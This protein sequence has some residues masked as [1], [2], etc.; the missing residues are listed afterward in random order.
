MAT[1]VGTIQVI[2]ILDTSQ[3]KAGVAQVNAANKNMSSST[4]SA[5]SRMRS[6]LNKVG[7]AAVA[8]A[9]VAAGA[10]IIK[11]LGNA[12]SRVDTLNNFPKVMANLGYGAA[13]AT[14]AINTLDKG[15]QGLPT[16]LDS[17]ASALQ[18]IA[19]SAKSLDYATKLTLALNNALIAGGKPAELQATAMEQFSQAIAKGK[20][21]LIEWRSVATAMP[22]QMKQLANSLGYDKWQQ[23]A[24]AV[25]DGKLSFEDV[26]DAIIKLNEKG[27]GKFPSFAEQ[28]KNAAGGLRTSI[29]QMNTAITRGIGEVIKSIGSDN[30]SSGFE[31]IGKGFENGL[32]GIATGI[33]IV[34]QFL[35]PIID[36]LTEM[37]N[38]IKSDKQFMD[39]L[40]LAFQT[41]GMYLGWLGQQFQLFIEWA[42]QNEQVMEGLKIVAIGLAIAIGAAV[43]AFAAA[44]GVI[45]GAVVLVTAAIGNARQFIVDSFNNISNAA[46]SLGTWLYNTWNSIKNTI[47]TVMVNIGNF[48]INTWNNIVNAVKTAINNIANFAITIFNSIKNF[49]KG[50]MDTNKNIISGAWNWILNTTRNICN[51]IVNA[52]SNGVNRAVGFVRGMPDRIKGFFSGAASWLVNAGKSILDGLASGIR[53][54][55]NV[56][57]K[58]LEGVMAGIRKL[59]PSSPAKEGPFS[60]KGWTLYSGMSMMDALAS[61]ITRESAVAQSAMSSAMSGIAGSM[62]YSLSAPSIAPISASGFDVDTSEFSS[63]E[64]S[65]QTT[66]GNIYLANDVDAD[67]FLRKLSGDQEITS[68]GLVPNQEYM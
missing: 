12:V 58:A 68:A 33:K 41:M 54:A 64:A 53:S 22:G 44:V 49:I 45:V 6:T 13:E 9:A 32:K 29:T 42:S 31:A 24:E 10:A 61:G 4:E 34:Q 23:M 43:V 35:K 30:I 27:L 21:D 46:T 26:Q 57:K 14:K 36:D 38:K 62:G 3:Y 66:I 63:G 1:T 8:A 48:L 65:R 39:N 5:G 18:N 47:L 52:I 37:F 50:V 67:R 28:A 15:V 51:N 17:I 25:T 2:A 20:P 11:N 7:L 19:P 59:L 40:N 60:G 56:P 16:S 55:A